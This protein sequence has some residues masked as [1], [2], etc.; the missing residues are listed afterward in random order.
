VPFLVGAE[1]HCC[2]VLKSDARPFPEKM[3]GEVTIPLGYPVEGLWFL[4]GATYAGQGQAGLYQVQYADGTVL[5]I[6][7]VCDENIRDWISPPALLPREK[8]TQSRIAWTG[9][10]KVFPVA[11]VF[12]ML[13]VNPT[14]EVPVKAVRFANPTRVACPILISLT[15]VARDEKAAADRAA[16]QARA[17]EGLTKGLAA[18]N[19]G[20]DAEAR[21]L[22]SQAVKED[23]SLEA[24]YQALLQ[25]CE[26]LKDEEGVLAAC[27]AW[28]AAGAR[29]PLPYNRLGQILEGRKDYKGALDAYTRSLQVEWNQPPTIEAKARLE[30]LVNK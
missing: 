29:S 26:R 30:K 24:A 20:K 15:A 12:Q 28:V 13:W 17:K 27:R 5:D 14:P 7:L 25:T 16:A 8:G 10:T 2:V 11:C 21:D 18:F 3:P 19:A 1:P 4:H 6:S 22:L 9:T 23:P